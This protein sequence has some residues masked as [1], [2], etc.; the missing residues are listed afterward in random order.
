[1]KVKVRNLSKRFGKTQAAKRVSFEMDA[2]NIFGFV[3]PNGAGKTTTMRI[4]ATL[5]D[6]DSGDA[7]FDGYSVREHPEE[8]RRAVGYVPDLLPAYKDMTVHEYIDFFA[9]AYGLRGKKLRTSVQDIEEFTGITGMLDKP[10]T[11]LSKGMKQRV[12]V[13]RALVHDPSVLLLDEPAAGLDPRA[14]VELRELL[15]ALADL[16]K[17]ILISSHILKELTEICSGV[18]IIERGE[19]LAEGPVERILREMKPHTD[20]A[21]RCLDNGEI[22]HRELSLLPWVKDVRL[23]G[24]R[25]VAQVDGGDERLAE[26]LSVLVQKGA[27]IC[28]FHSEQADMEDVFMNITKGEVQ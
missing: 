11:G 1:M 15:S 10:V 14:R 9:R 7:W 13:G 8:A 25:V 17:T 24:G 16:G 3:G 26:I 12:S 22:A 18:I 28:E 19:V 4:L 5:E 23:D 21:I 6:A 2:G 20:V 27:P